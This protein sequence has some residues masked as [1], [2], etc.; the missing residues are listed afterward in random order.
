MLV[1]RLVLAGLVLTAALICGYALAPDPRPAGANTRALFEDRPYRVA[2]L[3]LTFIDTDRETSPNRDYAGSQTRTLPTLLWHPID[4][5]GPRPLI[6]FSHGFSAHPRGGAYLAS[7]LASRGYVVA[8][9]VYPL[10]HF[11]AP[12]DPTLLD[13]V[14]QPGDISFLLDELLALSAGDRA[15]TAPALR[16]AIDAQ[17]IG[18]A[19][20]SLGAM[21]SLLVAFHPRLA[22]A[23]VNAVA[24]LAPPL[25]TF[26]TTYFAH[27]PLP[28]LI[29]TA[30]QDGVLPP[31]S[32]GDRAGKLAPHARVFELRGGSHIGFSGPARLLRALSRPD[33]LTCYFV[34]GNVDASQQIA[35]FA[36]LGSPAEGIDTQAADD[37]CETEP[38]G[39]VIDPR[40]QQIATR[41]VVGAFFD[42]TFAS[43][44][45]ERAAAQRYLDESATAELGYLLNRSAG[46]Q[47]GR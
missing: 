44:A 42:A 5:P 35:F 37:I 40:L 32:H 19:G 13:V 14:N 17:R 9:A 11:G 27:R 38:V 39:R 28:L 31:T 23:R 6:V 12:G 43:S 47:S 41:V 7:Y 21:T 2:A 46:Y 29:L 24:A 22:D 1:K 34:R 45:R 3:E 18:V 20:V 10:T 4:A 8:A 30:A 25:S 16:G 26:T 33:D 15:E 36:G